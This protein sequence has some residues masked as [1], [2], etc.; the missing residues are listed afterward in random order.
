MLS[1]I[2]PR[3]SIR[4]WTGRC[5][6]IQTLPCTHK[7]VPVFW[8]LQLSGRVDSYPSVEHRLELGTTEHPVESGATLTDH[9]VKRRERLRMEGWVSD[10]L[11][12]P[13]RDLEP[14]GAT[15]TW[16]AIVELF[17]NRTPV[18]IVTS[19][20]VYRNMLIIRAVAPVNRRTGRALRFT[21][22]FAE[23]IFTSTDF[24]QLTP[25]GVSGPAAHRTSQVDGG[26]RAARAVEPAPLRRL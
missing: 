19:L 8:G 13:G 15:D 2:P 25:D 3:T 1:T 20:R 22:D 23:V 26:D 4:R 10:L 17:E 5:P 6:T 16:N 18:T 12:A 11:P 14:D 9:A 21:I 24:Q 7:R